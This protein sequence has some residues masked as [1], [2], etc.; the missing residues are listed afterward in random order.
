MSDVSTSPPA[1]TTSEGEAA[2]V[3]DAERVA[4][5]R[6]RAPRRRPHRASSAML[7]AARVGC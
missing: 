1:P 3:A 5:G 2:A 4:R 7:K 6:R